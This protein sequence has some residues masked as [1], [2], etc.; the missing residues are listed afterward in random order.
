MPRR[1]SLLV[2]GAIVVAIGFLFFRV[3]WPL[4]ASLFFAGMLAIL[5]WPAYEWLVRCFRGYRRLAAIATTVGIVCVVVLPTA[6][7]MSVAGYQL[8]QAG[9]DVDKAFQGNQSGPVTAYPILE[10]A[11]EFLEEN[12]SAEMYDKAR[13]LAEDGL[14]NVT[15]TVY[16]R[17]V[18]L[19]G[20][21]I[22]FVVGLIVML[23]SLYYA[24]VDGPELIRVVRKLSPLDEQEEEEL[25]QRFDN[26]CRGVVLGTV[27]S[28]LVQG[29]LA[30]I[31]FAIVGVDWIWML[32]VLTMFFSMIP[33]LGAGSVW[34]TVSIALAFD[35]R[36]WAAGFL[37]AYG[38]LV[39]SLSDNF[40]RAYVL[41]NRAN[42][43]PLIAFITVLGA[44]QVIGL[45]GIFVGPLTAAF[46][47]ALV[48]TLQNRLV[49][50]DPSDPER[51]AAET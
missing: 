5:F 44:L 23:L 43:H 17:T 8:F 42:M 2:V 11:N 33:F 40:V 15:Q 39:V 3:I 41:H 51:P 1:A 30:G 14:T 20:G 34:I 9:E 25:F 47:F 7:L 10:R 27:V 46:F 26:V 19:A 21:L 16:E 32:I 18:D 36:W 31:G 37:V 6:G 29:L 45:W 13:K 24:F 22:A 38:T 48:K 50:S 28:A 12:L 35:E 49:D 4:I